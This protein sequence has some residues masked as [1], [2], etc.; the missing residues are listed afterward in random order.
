MKQSE[1]KHRRLTSAILVCKDLHWALY[2][3][4]FQNKSE[5]Y[6]PYQLNS[7]DKFW[8]MEVHRAYYAPQMYDPIRNWAHGRWIKN[9]T[10]HVPETLVIKTEPLA[11]AFDKIARLYELYVRIVIYI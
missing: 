9:R 2:H 6:N 5:L 8:Q 1:D 11:R 7:L 4:W 10:F 3:V